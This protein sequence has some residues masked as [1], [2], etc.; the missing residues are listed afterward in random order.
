MNSECNF[1]MPRESGKFIAESAT[2]VILKN[3]EI[4]KFAGIILE[5]FKCQESSVNSCEHSNFLDK[6]DPKVADLILFIDTLNF[7]FW[8]D[9][10]NLKWKVNGETGY[11]ALC[12]AIKR[13]LKA[14]IPITDAIFLSKITHDELQKILQGDQDSGEI[15]LLH[16]RVQNLNEVGQVLIKKYNGTF[17]EC[18]KSCNNSAEKLLKLIVHN[19]KC[20]RDEANYKN[21]Q[22]SFYKRAQIL[23]AD[24]WSCCQ[25]EGLGAFNDID[26]ITMFPDYRVPQVLIYFGVMQY[27]NELLNKLQSGV[28]LEQRSVEEIEI[29]GCSIAAV[30][31]IIDEIKILKRENPTLYLDK[32]QY[33]SIYIDYFL[34]EYRRKHAEKLKD[35]PYHKVRTIFY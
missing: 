1:L 27:N 18:I 2:H 30:E 19:F 12:A 17:V 6:N 5:N 11:F 20:F 29:R 31:R 28:T 22:V 4:K 23:V 13:A 7:C 24:I 32:L 16:E 9:A 26:Y 10:N 15:P 8:N 34:W 25:G 33:N 35:I 14:G 21:Y 3:A